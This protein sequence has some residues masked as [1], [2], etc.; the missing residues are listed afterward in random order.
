[1]PGPAEQDVVTRL[2]NALAERAAR[3]APS[4]VQVHGRPRRP[5][6]GILIAA[7]RVVTTSHSVEWEDGV[8]VRSHTG[9]LRSATVVGSDP[10]ADLIL[11]HVPGLDG[12]PIDFAATRPRVGELAL[13]AGRSWRGDPRARL[14]MISG[15][16]GPL[17]MRDGTRLDQT[18]V[19]S[20][21][22]Y[23]GFS[24]SAVVGADGSLVGM[25]SAGLF[26][27]TAMALPGAVAAAVVR[28]VEQHGGARRGFLG[29]SSQ[30]V[31]VPARQRQ[32][33]PGDGGLVVLDVVEGGPA[34]RAGLM[35]GDI[36]V[37]A[38]GTPLRAPEDLLALLTPDRIDRALDLQVLRGAAVQSVA[39][40]VGQRPRRP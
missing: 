21:T 35:V 1:M 15:V 4:I 37:E 26:R 3:I 33:A 22:P 27:G 40:T 28:E 18:L 31:R 8:K 24:G 39:I 10:G 17:Q 5:A 30:P 16:T 13:I 38:A 12:V 23:P 11:L 7:E 36:M 25:A 19:L 20:A 14:V 32:S 29:V 9:Q 2:S 34:D 6:S